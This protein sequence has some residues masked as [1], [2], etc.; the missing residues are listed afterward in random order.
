MN[1]QS[2]LT[3][4]FAG[5]CLF[6]G[7]SMA[8]S[9]GSVDG[10]PDDVVDLDTE[11]LPLPAEQIEELDRALDTTGPPGDQSG[12]STRPSDDDSQRGSGGESDEG[13]PDA[14]DGGEQGETTGDT[15][16]LDP[17]S[18]ADAGTTGSAAGELGEEGGGADQSDSDDA[19]SSSDDSDGGTSESPALQSLLDRLLAFLQWLLEQAV[20][21]LGGLVL[22][23]LV[24]LAIHR[25]ERLR[26]WLGAYLGDVD[27][28]GSDATS[29]AVATR[30]PD[31]A[32]ERQWLE[33]VTRETA[34]D[35]PA[36]TPR[37]R[38]DAVVQAGLPRESV[39]ELV[40][41]V[42]AVRYGETR[43]TPSEVREARAYVERCGGESDD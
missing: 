2:V 37:E 12:S 6:A 25:R 3:L 36:A 9:L 38:A 1:L 39:T 40:D 29:G 32:V 19:Q 11:S 33:L 15:G 14:G 27:R 26:E 4:L 8:T 42:E 43:V 7:V 17:Q 16:E 41:L 34:L 28:D 22:L 10:T 13:A 30:D 35:D 24:A 31:N 18:A 5:C 20:V 23:G 21:L